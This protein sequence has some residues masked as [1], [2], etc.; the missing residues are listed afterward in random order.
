MLLGIGGVP[1]TVARMIAD[2]DL[3]DIGCHAGT[4]SG[5][6]LLIHKA[7]KLTKVRKEVS[8]GR[9]VWNLA[10]GTHEMCEW[11]ATEPELFRPVCVDFTRSPDR[12]E[13]M[14]NVVSINGRVEIDL[15]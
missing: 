11:P 10:I 7:G 5:A 9:P 6:F 15:L 14:R 2:S 8:Q 12:L 13:R 1:Y 3:R 4:I